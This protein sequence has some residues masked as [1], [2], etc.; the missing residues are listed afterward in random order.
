MLRRTGATS[1][2]TPRMF[3]NYITT[4]S[5]NVNYNLATPFVSISDGTAVAPTGIPT[6]QVGSIM[7]RDN[8]GV[9]EK[10]TNATASN[11]GTWT[12]V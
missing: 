8:A 4:A 7:I 10:S 1:T 6:L 11:N 3:G 9:L 12:A 2:E 5:A